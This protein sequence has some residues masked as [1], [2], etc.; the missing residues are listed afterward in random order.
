MVLGIILQQLSN[1]KQQG[2]QI[3]YL[4]TE[5]NLSTILTTS[6]KYV[7]NKARW[8]NRPHYGPVQQERLSHTGWLSITL[9]FQ[10]GRGF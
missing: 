4:F 1:S 8:Q 10:V 2:F 3:R 6:S 9:Q 5:T 7:G